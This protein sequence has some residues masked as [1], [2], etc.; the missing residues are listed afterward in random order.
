MSSDI[1]EFPF[2]MCG[3]LAIV[4]IYLISLMMQLLWPRMVM[5]K[6][7]NMKSI[8]DDFSADEHEEDKDFDTE[9]ENESES[10]GVYILCTTAIVCYNFFFVIHEFRNYFLNLISLF[11]DYLPKRCTHRKPSPLVSRKD[12][13]DGESFLLLLCAIYCILSKLDNGYILDFI[14]FFISMM[15]VLNLRECMYAHP[16]F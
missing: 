4:L 12:G 15:C 5:K 10:E 7:L 9:S 2:F 8:G 11:S 3:R 14:T 6:W 13:N 1:F 16:M